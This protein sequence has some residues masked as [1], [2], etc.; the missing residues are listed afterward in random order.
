MTRSDDA[1]ESLMREAI[2]R[3]FPPA[4]DNGDGPT[5]CL[6]R[7]ERQRL[8]WELARDDLATRSA[9]GFPVEQEAG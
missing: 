1:Y 2:P 7:V 9:P 6:M 3:G 8:L 5:A 4:V